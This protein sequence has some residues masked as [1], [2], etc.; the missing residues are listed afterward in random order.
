[1]SKVYVIYWSGTGNTMAMASAVADGAREKGV[2]VQ[3]WNV[4]TRLLLAVHPWEWNNWKSQAWSR[5]CVIWMLRF[6]E[7]Q[8]LYLVPM[9]G[10][11]VNG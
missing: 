1:M 10:E 4:E 5:L 3:L 6:L 7:K 8:L 11:M 9:D 2:D